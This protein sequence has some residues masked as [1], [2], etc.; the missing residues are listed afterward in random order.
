M[1][2]V[3]EI[4]AKLWSGAPAG[5]IISIAINAGFVK[6]VYNPHREVLSMEKMP[7]NAHISMIIAESVFLGV[8]TTALYDKFKNLDNKK[9]IFAVAI[10]GVATA[11]TYQDLVLE[12][13]SSM[14]LSHTQS[15]VDIYNNLCAQNMGV[16]SSIMSFNFLNDFILTSAISVSIARTIN[17]FIG[18]N[19]E[20]FENLYQHSNIYTNTLI[21]QL[22][23]RI[24]LNNYKPTQDIYT[25]SSFSFLGICAG[26]NIFSNYNRHYSDSMKPLICSLAVGGALHY[27]GTVLPSNEMATEIILRGG[28]AYCL[29]SLLNYATNAKALNKD[30]LPHMITGMFNC[31]LYSLFGL[32]DLKEVFELNDLSIFMANCIH[33]FVT[34]VGLDTVVKEISSYYFNDYLLPRN[35]GAQNIAIQ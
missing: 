19:I 2:V 34:E 27:L 22:C 8:T 25:L 4:K 6:S 15:I 16:F 20:A 5:V 11:V 21:S 23:S 14:Y 10:A 29:G 28:S 9:W 18:Y 32:L 24:L 30:L 1:T 26:L 3:S 35:E 31:A 12:E 33:S 17:Y 13:I 7:R